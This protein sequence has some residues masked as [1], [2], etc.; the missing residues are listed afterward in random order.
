MLLPA[1]H[2]IPSQDM[3]PAQRDVVYSTATIPRLAQLAPT[4]TSDPSKASR[5]ESSAVGVER[6]DA[7][8][9]RDL[10]L[11]HPQARAVAISIL[12]L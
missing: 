1:D 3:A 6:C 4:S 8:S 11:L 2:R 12:Y 5:G 9:D 7:V 10:A